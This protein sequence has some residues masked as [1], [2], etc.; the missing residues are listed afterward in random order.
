MEPRDGDV[1]QSA[2]EPRTF[3]DINDSSVRAF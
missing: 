2:I 1:D 3:C